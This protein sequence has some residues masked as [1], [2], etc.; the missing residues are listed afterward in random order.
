MV[1]IEW[2]TQCSTRGCFQISL[3]STCGKVHANAPRLPLYSKLC[4]RGASGLCMR[5]KGQPWLNGAHLCV[6]LSK[7]PK[8]VTRWQQT[9]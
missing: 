4:S 3:R 6:M 8:M 1:Y 2:L 5:T 7:A 9:P